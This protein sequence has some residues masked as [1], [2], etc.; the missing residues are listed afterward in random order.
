MKKFC[1]RSGL[2][3]L[4]CV[5]VLSLC[6]AQTTKQPTVE[7]HRTGDRTVRFERV[8]GLTFI[9]ASVNA[10]GQP[11]S[12]PLDMVLDTGASYTVLKPEVAKELGLHGRGDTLQS[13]G[14][15]KGA[16]ETLHL[17]DG[18]TLNFAGESLTGRTIAT[19]PVDYIDREAGRKTD[20]LLGSDIFSSF[21][22]HEDY[23]G[24]TVT[25]IAPDKFVAP[26]GF[27]SV[28]LQVAGT[29]SLVKL[30]VQAV[31]GEKITGTVLL[32]SGLVGNLFLMKPLLDAHPQLKNEKTVALPPV[33]AVGG[34]MKL[35][36]GR[37]ASLELGPFT[38]AGPTVIYQEVSAAGAGN[39]ML[40]GILGSGVLRR[41]DVIF[42]YP[43][44]KLWLKPNA[45]IGEPFEALTSGIQLTV[46]PPEFHKV[47]VR[48][49]IAGSVAERAG[50]KAGDGIIAIGHRQQDVSGKGA[51]PELTLAGVQKILEP[52]GQEVYLRVDRAGKM[53]VIHFRTRAMI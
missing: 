29:A 40:S 38:L 41:F 1:A 51:A 26:E 7:E 22:V 13:E 5:G 2:A 47:M 48:V 9:T 42:D 23:A 53:V 20:G 15:G 18:V 8:L 24:G 27:V 19:L 17:V 10:D 36:V 43:H 44:G 34:E 35:R 39:A 37:I 6:R 33:T 21:V 49:V 25:L 4:L 12:R 50:V 31:G 3:L 11:P 46:Q 32:D 14:L 16:D 28:P 45:T 52:D 30:T